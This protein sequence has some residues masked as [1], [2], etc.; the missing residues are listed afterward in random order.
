MNDDFEEVEGKA[1]GKTDSENTSSSKV[2]QKEDPLS[3][4]SSS[5]EEILRIQHAARMVYE[6][7]YDESV[8]RYYYFNARDQSS[9]WELPS[10][11]NGDDTFL[12]TPRSREL[13]VLKMDAGTWKTSETMTKEEAARTIQG[14]Y[15]RRKA[16]KLI[17]Q[18]IQSMYEKIY[19][20]QSNMFFYFK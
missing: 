6:K 12:L 16:R 14:M 9:S 2:E 11:F 1:E 15:K 4:S 19:D 20:E 7:V 5:P 10:E 8:G 13:M 3:S 17:V 18:A